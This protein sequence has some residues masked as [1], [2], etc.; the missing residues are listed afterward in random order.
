MT[1]EQAIAAGALWLESGF[2]AD[3]FQTG[4]DEYGDSVSTWFC[5]DCGAADADPAEGCDECG[6]GKIEPDDDDDD[7]REVAA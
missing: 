5:R 2:Y 3:R 7:T 1:L 4:V 6:F